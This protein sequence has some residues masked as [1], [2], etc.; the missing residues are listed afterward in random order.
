MK[1][2]VVL[3]ALLGAYVVLGLVFIGFGTVSVV[4]ASMP[5]A[6]SQE[7]DID[8]RVIQNTWTWDPGEIT[9]EAGTLVRLHITNEDT[10]D[11][12][13]AIREFN[14]DQRLPASQ[15]T[16]VEF[17]AS[18]SGDFEFYCSVYCGSG[19]FGQRGTLF[20]TGEGESVAEA[21]AA[22]APESDIPVRSA[23]D[24][25]SVLPYE[26]DEDGVKVFRLTA[27]V[28]MWDYGN[29]EP[30]ESW[31]YNGQLPGPE[32]RVTEGDRVRVEFTN[33]LPEATT[34]HWH[35]IDLMNWS[36]GVPGYTQEATRPGETFVYEFDAY[37]AGT[38]FYHT[39]GLDH[40]S[41]ARQMDMGLAGPII[42]EPRDYDRP[43]VEHTIVLT[44]RIN[45]GLFP[46]SG[47]VYPDTEPIRVTYGDRVRIR[48]I[49]A[50]SATFHP[51]HLHGH[52]FRVVATDGN[53]VPAGLELVKN[54]QTVM[55]GDTYDIEFIADN[56]GVWLFHCHELN[57]SAGGMATAVIYEDVI[58]GAFELQEGPGRLVTE[59]DF[60][61]M[62][63]L[64]GFGYTNCTDYCPI[65]INT[66]LDVLD[67]LGDDADQVQ[68]I[69]ISVD[70]ERDSPEAIASY[71]QAFDSRMVGLSGTREQVTNAIRSFGAFARQ[72][73]TGSAAGYSMDHS[74]A[75]YL[76]DPDGNFINWFIHD[77]GPE[78]VARAIRNHMRH[79]TV[80]SVAANQVG[81]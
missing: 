19:H 79:G 48:M 26:V 71:V 13:F 2:H 7:I 77:F 57:H 69:F 70:P 38:R 56:P 17:V 34:V 60:D 37:P 66:M 33:Y 63:R 25:I 3:R 51:M 23:E 76:M 74:K 52:Q 32:I 42:I 68:P 31:G 20:V 29:G 9:V 12:G 44:E 1:K 15:T 36:D 18:R 67:S 65:T 61:G 54:V 46:I 80:R 24:A 30:V 45:R 22:E 39:H 16:T 78:N 49:N 8:M 4:S 75:M 28:V 73:N 27:E 11:H 72:V 64:V 43:D 10:Y 14:V 5:V 58:D 40:L 55:P 62:Y 47:R 41:E 6:A 59:S 35:G 53:P 21:G 81:L 50:G